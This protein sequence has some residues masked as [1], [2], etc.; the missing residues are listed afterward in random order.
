VRKIGGGKRQRKLGVRT[1]LYFSNHAV[2]I[3]ESFSP[4]NKLF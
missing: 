4:C 1:Q 3:R 2:G